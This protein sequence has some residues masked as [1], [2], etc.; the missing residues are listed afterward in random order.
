MTSEC[1]TYDLPEV[2]KLEDCQELHSFLIKQQGTP[3]ALNCTAVTR[4][5]GL[6]AQMIHFAAGEWA[7]EDVDFSLRDLSPGCITS[8]TTL[9]LGGLVANEGAAG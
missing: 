8:L 7:G 3:V 2:M 1:A 5:S 6:A 4:I 9:G